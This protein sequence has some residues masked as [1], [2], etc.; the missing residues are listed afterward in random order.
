MFRYHQSGAGAAVNSIEAEVAGWGL[1][2][3]NTEKGNPEDCNPHHHPHRT[4]LRGRLEGK[5]PHLNSHNLLYE[6]QLQFW[7][8]LITGNKVEKQKKLDLGNFMLDIAEYKDIIGT[9]GWVFPDEGAKR[10]SLWAATMQVSWGY[11]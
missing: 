2:H 9:R 4:T 1:P 3:R 5:K 6:R 11:R 8:Q 7:R 10:P